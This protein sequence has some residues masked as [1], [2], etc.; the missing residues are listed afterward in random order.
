[1][2]RA[3]RSP[4]WA[5]ALGIVA[6]AVVIAGGAAFAVNATG[7]HD[8]PGESVGVTPVTVDVDDH[9]HRLHPLPRRPPPGRNGHGSRT[10]TGPG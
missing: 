10:D 9:A 2:E 8:Q 6:V 1:M 5:I 4:R 3:K 7:F